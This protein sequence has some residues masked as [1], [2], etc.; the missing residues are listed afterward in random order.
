[1]KS[2]DELKAEKEAIRMDRGVIV[3]NGNFISPPTIKAAKR[4]LSKNNDIIAKKI[5]KKCF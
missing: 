5:H 4:L 2:Y 1:M 3:H